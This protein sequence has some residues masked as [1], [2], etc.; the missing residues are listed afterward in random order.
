MRGKCKKSEEIFRCYSFG[1]SEPPSYSWEPARPG[2]KNVNYHWSTMMIIIFKVM[3][4]IFEI[5]TKTK[6]IWSRNDHTRGLVNLIGWAGWPV[7]CEVFTIIQ[8]NL[9]L[10][11]FHSTDLPGDVCFC[12]LHCYW[13]VLVFLSNFSSYHHKVGYMGLWGLWAVH[14]PR[15][16]ILV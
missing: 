16:K 3:V 5:E 14:I 11:G 1:A 6:A 9:E 10:S 2:H 8:G 7:W 4:I 12:L 13:F 15:W